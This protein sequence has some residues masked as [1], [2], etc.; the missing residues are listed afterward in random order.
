MPP[1]KIAG[2]RALHHAEGEDLE[3]LSTLSGAQWASVPIIDRAFPFR[4]RELQ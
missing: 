4:A 2:A 1:T 3:K